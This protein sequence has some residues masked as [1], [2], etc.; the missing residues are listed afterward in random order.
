MPTLRALLLSTLLG[1]L[2]AARPAVPPQ[3]GRLTRN[4]T[5]G[6]LQPIPDG[7]SE[8]ESLSG[9]RPAFLHVLAAADHG[10]YARA[11]DAAGRGDWTAARALAAQGQNPLPR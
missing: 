7:S 5:G 4:G 6:M 8:G 2:A 1:S 9:Q 10:V 3:P 11:F